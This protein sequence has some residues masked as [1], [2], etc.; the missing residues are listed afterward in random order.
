MPRR[1]TKPNAGTL[2]LMVGTT[3]GAFLFDSDATR[4]RFTMRGPYFKGNAVYAMALDGREGRNRIWA[5]VANPSF[6]PSL[7]WS[8]DFGRTWVEPRIPPIR[9]P[10]AAKA[11]VANI[12]QIVPARDGEADR[13]Y[14]GVDPGALFESRDNGA[15]WNLTRGLY[16]HP[17][18]KLWMP[19]AGGLCLH[20][21]VLDPEDR[22]RLWV[23]VST[24]GVY[25]SR[26]GGSTWNPTNRGIRAD[27]LPDK[28]P[29]FGQCVHKLAQHP[30]TPDR[31]YLQNHGG[32]YRS[33]DRARTWIDIGK[34][35]PS[36]FGFSLAVHP[37][38]PDTAYVIPLQADVFRCTPGAKLRV[39]RTR[40]AGR[41]WKPLT[42][43]LPQRSAFETTLRDAMAADS[44]EPAGL[45]FGTRS[46]KLFASR[47]EG[48]SWQAVADGLP[49]I[50][51]VKVAARS[52]G[53]W[54]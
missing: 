45:Y 7:R 9:F 38:D 41:S 29:E 22:K 1:S 17:Q 47:D 11:S 53:R 36:D 34:G 40:D 16:D 6:G 33:D 54:R 4:R 31:F 27:Y 26:D 37:R 24:G 30:S 12:W 50:T 43:G 48:D 18:R 44:L 2:L 3:K 14:C 49:P 21:I 39:Y 15:S 42:K 8:E 52:S 28:Q 51:C 25:E 35:L 32:V 13:L 5:G 20:T 46:G 19:G 23:G 10:K